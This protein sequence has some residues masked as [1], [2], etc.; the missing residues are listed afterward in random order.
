MSAS[1]FAQ[2]MRELFHYHNAWPA[3]YYEERLAIIYG[4]W[5]RAGDHAI[6]VGAHNGFHAS[7]ILD[8]IGP[9]GQ[10]TCVEPL[11]EI[12]AQLKA[13]LHGRC[14]NVKFFNGALSST[15]GKV[16]FRRA[17]GL[18]GESGLK[19]RQRY[20]LPDIKVEEITVECRRLDDLAADCEALQYIKIDTEGAELTILESGAHIMAE[21]R[22][23]ISVEW[24]SDTYVSY[25]HS[26][27]DLF[28]FARS[29]GY[30]VFDLFINMVRSEREWLEV[31]DRASWD[32]VLVPDEKVAA[33]V[34]AQTT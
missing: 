21:L 25:G 10:L 26:A 1:L 28:V 12:F 30:S 4:K 17:V 15:E 18:P 8:C 6:D 2:A 23:V 33:F 7:Q 31:S 16:T 34:Y 27:R 32:Y 13:V 9:N 29:R 24:G 20:G 14:Q 3:Q 22:P 19:E 5:L 11:P